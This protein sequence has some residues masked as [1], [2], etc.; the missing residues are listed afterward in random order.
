MRQAEICCGDVLEVLPA[1]EA[2]S[3]DACLTDPPYGLKFMGKAWDHGV[4]GAEVWREV[5]RV[6]KPGAMLMAFGGTRTHHRLTVA[7]EDAG[8]EI[9][10]CLM[11]LYGSGFPKSRD[12]SKAIDKAAGAVRKVVG[13]DPGVYPDSDK[14]GT[15]KNNAGRIFS[16]GSATLGP[17]PITT[18]ATPAA[19][20]W[21][22]YGTALKPAWEPV[23]LAMKPLDGTFAGNALKHG[24]AGLNVDGGRVEVDPN[25][26]VNTAR[27][28]AHPSH[29]YGK[30]ASKERGDVRDMAPPPA[31]RWPAN[32]IL[33]EDAAAALDRQAGYSETPT[34]VSMGRSRTGNA[35]SIGSGDE[36]TRGIPCFGDSGGPSRFFRVIEPD[37]APCWVCGLPLRRGT[38]SPCE[39]VELK[40]SSAEHAT[41]HSRT[42]PAPSANSVPR[43]VQTRRKKQPAQSVE[44]AAGPCIRC[45]MSIAPVLAEL[46]NL[47]R[48]EQLAGL[49]SISG[50]SRQTLRLCLALAVEGRANTDTTPTIHDLK[51][52]IG[53]VRDATQINTRTAE[54]A[55]A[56]GQQ[57]PRSFNRG[58]YTA[59]VSASERGRDNDHPTL[60]PVSLTGYLANLLLPPERDTP[61]RLLVPFSGAG[62]EI[63][64]A[65]R[66]G[67]DESVGIEQD[68]EHC[69][70]S[71]ERIRADAPLFNRVD[72]S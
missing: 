58:F 64:G 33:D 60:K 36:V 62:S 46:P 9:R 8:F 68:A 31:G 11:W 5:L 51:R 26:P 22:G 24:V 7:I 69:E 53:S 56:S 6:L 40:N 57:A 67:W 3:F 13:F 15:S 50:L 35:Y 32:L 42:T 48:L 19:R 12:I 63:I 25:D 17:S 66:S 1:L 70:L 34:S 38:M 29:S 37:P 71:R 27:Y 72:S 2:D 14:W 49:A 52:W 59:K 55:S 41:N 43:G 30:Y 10:D 16:G 23:I 28:H 20:T 65:L 47:P 21:D 54:T 18:P 4:P 61:R 45:S 44:F 39:N